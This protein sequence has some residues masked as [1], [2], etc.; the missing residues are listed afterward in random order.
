VIDPPQELSLHQSVRDEFC[1]EPR[2]S[3]SVREQQN[4]GPGG[5]A[6]AGGLPGLS[7]RGA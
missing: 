1:R 7:G 2:L 5:R 3:P 4:H 6:A